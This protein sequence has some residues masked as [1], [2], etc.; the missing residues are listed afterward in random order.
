MAELIETLRGM[1]DAGTADYTI[2]T[3]AYWDGDH[4]Q[5][6]LD[7]HRVDVYFE[8]LQPVEK[9]TSGGSV[10]FHTY[11]SVYKNYE[12]TS[13]G[14]AIFWLEDGTG[15]DVGTVNYTVDYLNGRITF[16]AD[17]EGTV[18]Y[19]TG[20]SYD[21]NA[22]AADVW[23]QKASHYATRAVDFSTDNHRFSQSQ[24]IR[25]CQD[26]ATYYASMGAPVVVTLE[27]SDL[28]VH[29]E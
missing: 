6:V 23:R 17:T 28:N 12:Q 1:T 22:A 14:T 11:Y 19:L 18:Y 2:G 21:L 26:M 27:R 10:E 16:T 9:Y 3:A 5:T 24:I 15:A 20:R 25:H 8:P 7:R 4:I 29:P 13:G